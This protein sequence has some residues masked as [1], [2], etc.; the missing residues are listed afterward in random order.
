VFRNVSR[1]TDK[2]FSELMGFFTSAQSAV[3]SASQVLVCK[4]YCKILESSYVLI[5]IL[6]L[7]H[8]DHCVCAQTHKVEGFSVL[9]YN[10]YCAFNQHV[11]DVHAYAHDGVYC[12]N[13]DMP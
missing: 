1:D 11:I 7:T 5:M 2:Y 10:W 9:W 8:I 4:L 3:I 12:W 13:G 6:N